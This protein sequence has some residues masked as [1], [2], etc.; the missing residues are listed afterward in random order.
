ML[1][2]MPEFDAWARCCE[3]TEMLMLRVLRGSN[4]DAM[5]VF[6]CM[7]SSTIVRTRA[8]ASIDGVLLCEP[9]MA[10]SLLCAVEIGSMLASIHTW[11]S[12]RALQ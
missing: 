2:A 6:H 4:I 12:N 1:A 8:S 7:L 5:R 3:H 11:S 10:R 9:C